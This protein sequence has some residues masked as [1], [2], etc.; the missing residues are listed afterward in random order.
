MS[1]Y[2]GRSVPIS[3]RD[4][5]WVKRG[6]QRR[7]LGRL[8]LR[9]FDFLDLLTA[10]AQPMVYALIADRRRVP[11]GTVKREA[12]SLRKA[13]LVACALVDSL[14]ETGCVA[15]EPTEEGRAAFAEALA[16]LDA[17]IERGAA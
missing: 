11:E 16:V 9:E 2:E 5:A 17:R 15:V 3:E 8:T 4:A 1:R 10:H 7:S 12:H 13:G 14:D 6:G